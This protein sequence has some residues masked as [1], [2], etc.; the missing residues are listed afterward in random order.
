[1]HYYSDRV[2]TAVVNSRNI[3][4][5]AGWK[6]MWTPLLLRIGLTRAWRIKKWGTNEQTG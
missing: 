2:R 3:A 4:L 6:M 1:M 5:A